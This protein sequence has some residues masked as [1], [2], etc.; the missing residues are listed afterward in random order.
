MVAIGCGIDEYMALNPAFKGNRGVAGV[1]AG[2]A[3]LLPP[4]LLP[5]PTTWSTA[6]LLWFRN[7]SSRRHFALR[8]LNHT[9]NR[10]NDGAFV[11][12]RASLRARCVRIIRTYSSS[13]PP[14]SYLLSPRILL[15]FP[16]SSTPRSSASFFHPSNHSSLSPS[17]SLLSF[18]FIALSIIHRLYA[19]SHCF[20]LSFFLVRSLL[21]SPSLSLSLSARSFSPTYSP[22]PAIQQPWNLDTFSPTLRPPPPTPPWKTH[23]VEFA[24]DSPAVC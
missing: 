4:P 7:F 13:H 17:L 9:C 21:S 10:R 14:S 2:G 8:L 22:R 16:H 11:T 23:A 6:A 19:L 5:P 1:A 3:V 12:I 24:R 20:S 15:L 18:F